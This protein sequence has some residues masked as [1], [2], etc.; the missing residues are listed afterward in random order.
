MRQRALGLLSV[1]T[2][3]VA[4]CTAAPATA[5]PTAAPTAAPM[6]QRPRLPRQPRPRLRRAPLRPSP[7]R[8]ADGCADRRTHGAPTSPPAG[9]DVFT[10]T[11]LND[12][13]T[14]FH[15]I[16]FQ[17]GNQFMIFQLLYNCWSRSSRRDDDHPDLA[18]TWDVSADAT[19]FTF[20]LNPNAK[21]H[22][23]TPVT[24]DDVVYTAAAGAQCRGQ[25]HRDLPDHTGW[26]SR[27]P[28]RSRARRTSPRA[29]RRSTPTP[30]SSRWPRRTPSC[31][32]T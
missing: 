27:A 20:N 17:T 21:W 6:R 5:P 3:V 19:T 1:A 8:R 32:G 12:F 24:A 26:S 28:T 13:P 15:P 18:D 2:F 25:L 16:C 29:S 22:D 9:G 30:S 31:S 4:A 14:C 23:G 7:D 11:R 10:V